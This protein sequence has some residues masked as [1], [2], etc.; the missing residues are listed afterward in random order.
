VRAWFQTKR[1]NTGQTELNDSRLFAGPPVAIAAAREKHKRLRKELCQL[2]ETAAG[3]IH[4][5][6]EVIAEQAQALDDLQRKCRRA[7]DQEQARQNAEQQASLARAERRARDQEQARQ[8]AEQQAS[9][10]HA[11]RRQDQQSRFEVALGRERRRAA[12]VAAEE[13]AKFA[14]A[15]RAALVRVTQAASVAPPPDLCCPILR[16]LFED[17]V[18]AADGET[19][20]RAAIEQW[21]VQQEAALEA[22]QRELD[23]T[24]NSARAQRTLSAGVVSPMGH[25]RL[26]DTTMRPNR[27]LMRLAHAWR[28]T[29]EVRS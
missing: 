12:R 24:G 19:Y 28:D 13:A 6:D 29:H 2:E 15:Q 26:E 1:V 22:A 14:A 27:A 5:R 8:A 10:A 3:Q 11:E 16:E 9:L 17:P 23:E 18:S 21:V 20:E 4:Q 7:R 25:G